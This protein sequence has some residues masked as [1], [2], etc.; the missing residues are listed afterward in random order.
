MRTLFKVL[1][2]LLGGILLA[3]IVHVARTVFSHDH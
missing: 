2:L 1:G 3:A